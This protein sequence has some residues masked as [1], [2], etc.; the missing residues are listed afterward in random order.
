MKTLML[1]IYTFWALALNAH[2]S[3]NLP[4]GSTLEL[5]SLEIPGLKV[6]GHTIEAHCSGDDLKEAFLTRRV[7]LGSHETAYANKPERCPRLN[8]NIVQITRPSTVHTTDSNKEV[9]SIYL[10]WVEDTS[11]G[12]LAV[13]ILRP[14]AAF[15]FRALCQTTYQEGPLGLF[16]KNYLYCRITPPEQGTLPARLIFRIR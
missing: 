3:L 6:D 13:P 1:V 7:T 15:Q 14:I 4:D 8:F 16:N 2:A 11:V 5:V 10:G 9:M 12:M